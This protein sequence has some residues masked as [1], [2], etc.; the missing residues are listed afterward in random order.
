MFAF[1]SL[2]PCMTTEKNISPKMFSQWINPLSSIVVIF[3]KA[4]R[5]N[6][7]PILLTTWAT[8]HIKHWY[9]LYCT[10]ISYMSW[11][12]KHF[13]TMCCFGRQTGITSNPVFITSSTAYNDV[14]INLIFGKV[15]MCLQNSH[16]FFARKNISCRATDFT[17]VFGLK[18]DFRC[19]RISNKPL[20]CSTNKILS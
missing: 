16:K 3:N 13:S 4:E 11:I 8:H 2:K 14:Y 10:V 6:Y 20:K 18:H 7:H 12:E 17:I 5:K 9:S 15:V 1:L 19:T